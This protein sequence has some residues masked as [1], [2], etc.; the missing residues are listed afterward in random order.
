MKDKLIFSMILR[1]N[2]EDLV[3]IVIE[4]TKMIE[5]PVAIK[6]KKI[7][8]LRDELRK[9]G[10]TSD[11]GVREIES[12]S[13]VFPDNIQVESSVVK[14]IKTRTFVSRFEYHASQFESNDILM[15]K[16]MW[17]DLE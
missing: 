13:N 5:Q 17:E 7:N 9:K 1:F 11:L 12:I 16:Q 14:V 8:E 15:L 2:V 10:I 3:S 4:E 6:Y